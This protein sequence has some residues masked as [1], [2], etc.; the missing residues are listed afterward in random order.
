[1]HTTIK[2]VTIKSYLDFA[3]LIKEYQGSHE[4]N[5][6]FA[7]KHKGALENPSKLVMLWTKTNL[8]RLR[9]TAD[10][11]NFLH[12]FS[13][14]SNLI[15][16]LFLLMGFFAGIGLL[17]YS[18]H[19]PVNI[20]YYLLFAMMIPLLSMLI[21]IF[22]MISGGEVSNFFNLFFSLHWVEKFVNLFAFNSKI[23][24]LNSSFPQTL[25]KWIF[26]HRLQLFSLLFSVGL[27]LSLLVMVVSK[28]IA[29][30]W[31]T[32]LNVT[33]MA[34]HELLSWVAKPWEFLVPSAIPSVELVEMSQYFRLGETLNKEMVQN[35]DKLGAWWQFLAMVTLIYAIFLRAILWLVSR[36]AYQKQLEKDF[37]EIE[38]MEM[39]IREFQ[40]PYVSTE[41][42][43][44][45]QHLDI[46]EETDA[47]VKQNRR[48]AFNNIVGWNFS[49]D[50]I[51]LVN[52][53]KEIKGVHIDIVGGS[54]TFSKDQEIARQI[55]RTV[56]LYVK[57]W[58][59]PTMDFVDFLELLIESK[60]VDEIHVYPL[61]TVGRYY[62]SDAKEVAVWK[63][64]IQGLKSKKVWVI[65][66]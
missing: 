7:L 19:A 47:Q 14:V 2:K 34:F 5:R 23:K 66:A 52:D 26:I 8:F 55:S 60:K 29:F 42:P 65:D 27:L 51:A 21:T 28:D 24:T 3:Q 61:G 17:S 59:P 37:L 62:A 35:A 45:E 9:E 63:R 39:L 11:E 64:K 49:A 54:H 44:V 43:K 25:K 4:E 56:L 50:E 41:A 30:S 53:S 36:Y 40:T 20:I 6:V 48:R 15:G 1:M 57:S 38:G 18:G 33:P 12:H 22:S 16:F 46:V 13:S 32:T 10:S 31:S 58:E